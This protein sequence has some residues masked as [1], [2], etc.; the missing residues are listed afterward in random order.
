MKHY[1]TLT[2]FRRN[3]NLIIIN[4]TE[5][6]PIGCE[7]LIVYLRDV[8]LLLC[9]GVCVCVLCAVWVVYTHYE[10]YSIY[11]FYGRV[12]DLMIF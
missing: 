7:I 9:M 11:Q 3:S 8:T 4:C 1:K 12:N 6:L 2:L 5:T 10:N